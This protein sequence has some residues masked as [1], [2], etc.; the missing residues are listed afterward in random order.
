MTAP[1]RRGDPPTIPVVAAAI[2]R[3]GRVLCVR[4]APGG[5]TGGLW[6]LPG[7]KVERGEDPRAALQR[8]IAEELGC[9]IAVHAEVAT[10]A[11]AYTFG[12]IELT[13]YRC[14][15]TEGEPRLRE[16]DDAR[17]VASS[18]L[19][20][21][22]DLTWAPADVPAVRLLTVAGRAEPVL[23]ADPLIA[24]IG[25]QECGEPLVDLRVDGAVASTPEQNPGNPFYA[26][27]RRGL[28]ERLV[29]AQSALPDGLR[30]LVAEGYRPYDRQV[31]AFEGHRRRLL[32]DDPTL[33]HDESHL[34]ASAFISPPAIAP[35]VAGAAVDLTLVDADGRQLDLGTV[36]DASPEDSD[37]ACYTAAANISAEARR[38]RAILGAALSGAGLVNYPTEWWHWSYGDRYWALLT[39]ASHALYGPVDEP[40][41]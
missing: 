38:N 15:L 7:G 34:R 27:L 9:R 24:S 25:V 22:A 12:T 31:A 21:H 30:L 29:A 4:R 18:E 39:G 19:L 26:W 10:T 14:T 1:D 6:E 37:R 17:W 20:E 28:A 40:L 2:E 8:E 32:D 36:I 33:P 16:H 23:M 13:T 35:H 3:D 5:E 41:R 11:H